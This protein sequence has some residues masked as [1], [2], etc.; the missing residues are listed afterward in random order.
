[1]IEYLPVEL[2]AFE[3]CEEKESKKIIDIYAGYD[4]S[5]LLVK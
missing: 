5:V 1:M 4:F 3:D 2:K